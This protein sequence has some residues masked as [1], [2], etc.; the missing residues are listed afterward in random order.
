[1]RAER[2]AEEIIADLGPVAERLEVKAALDSLG[3]QGSRWRVPTPSLVVDLDAFDRNVALMAERARAAGVTLRP[4]AKSHKTSAL[5]HRQ[6]AAGAV[7]VCC[8]KLGEAEALAAKGVDSILVTSPIVGPLAAER[9]A[10][11]A[12]ELPGFEL[13][14]DHED[15]A[16][17]IGAAAAQLGASVGVVIDIDVGL[18]RTGASSPEQVVGIAKAIAG[19]PALRFNGVQAYGGQWQHM[20]GAEA[21]AAA[22]HQGM[23]TLKACIAA[24]RAAG[25]VVDRVTGGGTGTFA[26]DTAEGVYTERQVGSYALMDR[27]YRDCLGQDADGAFEQSLFVQAQVVSVNAPAWVTVDAGLK[28]LAT[29]GP[30]PVPAD[31]GRF[32]GCHYAFFGDEHGLLVRPKAAPQVL[33]GE[34][35]ELV[36]PHCDPTFDRYDFVYLVRGDALVDIVRVDGRGRAQ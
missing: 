33:R 10:R 6:I 24:L 4:H 21:R 11:L 9:A 22:V 5:A 26:A 2:T 20:A 16:A 1:M 3:D 35:L 8:A 25:F 29:D 19:A 31:R 28:A 12:L 23:E 34:R 36:A 18:G 17:E 32:A 7:G 14:V 30:A 13:V 27:E 15:G